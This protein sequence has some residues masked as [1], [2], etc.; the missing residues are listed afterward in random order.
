M[1]KIF[2]DP[3]EFYIKV[4]VL[5]Y[6]DSWQFYGRT[7]FPAL[8]CASKKN[9]RHP[10]QIYYENNNLLYQIG[11]DCSEINFNQA[12]V[13]YNH[14]YDHV[15]TS[16]IGPESGKLFINKSLF[17][18]AS[19]QEEVALSIVVDSPAKLQLFKEIV[20]NIQNDRPYEIKA[21]RELDQRMISK[22][23]KLTT[24]FALASDAA[25]ALVKKK[26]ESY[27]HALV[28][29]IGHSSSKIYTIHSQE[30]VRLFGQLEIGMH[31]YYKKI[32]DLLQEKGIEQIDYFWLI[33]QLEL[34]LGNIEIPDHKNVYT[35]DLS[36][37]IDNIR[38]DFNKNFNKEITDT[39]KSYFT[40]LAFAVDSIFIMGG[41]AVFNGDLLCA[42]LVNSGYN[43]HN[44]YIEKSPM[45]NIL[46]GTCYY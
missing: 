33:K 37:I 4:L 5:D 39:I 2:I 35:F 20:N 9:E 3:G 30:G 38:W 42:S 43:L 18:F 10:Q 14:S 22:S 8:T 13:D 15:P 7:F 32:I 23:I 34:G 29:D 36:L 16:K 45:Y 6:V 19:D 41:G 31:C 44:I 17:D 1:K 24:S 40:Q 25:C 46:L 21:Y 28:V 26:F 11:Y 12:F 27:S